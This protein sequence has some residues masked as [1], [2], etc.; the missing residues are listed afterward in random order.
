MSIAFFAFVSRWVWGS[1]DGNRIP[2]TLGREVCA[3]EELRQT[4]AFEASSSTDTFLPHIELLD[5]YYWIT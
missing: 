5:E 1:W 3:F 4:A 2:I